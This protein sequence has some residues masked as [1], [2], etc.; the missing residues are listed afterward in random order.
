MGD[1]MAVALSTATRTSPAEGCRARTRAR[2]R[3][4]AAD[5]RWQS[6]VI[7]R[8]GTMARAVRGARHG[9]AAAQSCADRSSVVLLPVLVPK[10][11]VRR[12]RA[13]A[14]RNRARRLGRVSRRRYRRAG[15]RL[16]V[17]TFHR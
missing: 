6:S 3:A 7:G 5:A 13:V 10:A 8:V 12:E 14:R 4:G 16:V 11:L 9:A 1:P 17:G 2:R 15:R